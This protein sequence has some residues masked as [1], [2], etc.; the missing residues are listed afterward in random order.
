MVVGF[1]HI[2]IKKHLSKFKDI[3]INFIKINN[4]QTNGHGMSWFAYKKYFLKSKRKTIIS[5]NF[6]ADGSPIDGK[7][8][9]DTNKIKK[10]NPNISWWC[11]IEPPQN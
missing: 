7:C 4:F 8:S 10:V 9:L 2:Q 5:Y 1:Q 11:N 3:K 6:S